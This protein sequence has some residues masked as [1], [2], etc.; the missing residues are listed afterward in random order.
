MRIPTY[1]AHESKSVQDPGGKWM[2]LAIW[3]WSDESTADARQRALVR[4]DALV[5]KL[6]NGETLNRYSYGDRPLREEVLQAVKTDRGLEAGVITRNAYGSAVL[7][8][9]NA[10]FVDIDLNEGGPSLLKQIQKLRGP[11]APSAEERAL[12]GVEQWAARNVGLGIRVYR[13]AA[14]LR[15]L[16]TNELFDP[17]KDSTLEM[18]RELASDPLYI[19][20]CRAQGC[21]RARLS[22]KPWRCHSRKPPSRYPWLNADSERRYR[23]WEEKYKAVSAR[24]ATCRLIKQIGNPEVHPDIASVLAIHDRMTGI[25]SNLPLA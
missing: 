3:Q 8:S 23:A 6:Q 22:P 19:R 7:N 17:T 16:I 9:V 5:A 13:T 14:G 18:L 12:D 21:F 11:A 20:L 10:M 2:K 15:G 25:D 4:I 1:W 24:Y